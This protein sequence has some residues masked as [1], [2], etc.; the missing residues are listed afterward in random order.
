MATIRTVAEHAGVSTATVSRVMNTPQQVSEGTRARVET[1]M[2]ELNFSRN[3]VAASLVTRRSDCIGLIVGG[4]SGAFFAPLVNIVEETVSAAG[5]YLIVSCGKDTPGKCWRRCSFCA[6][7]N[8]T[9]SSCSPAS[10]P[11]PP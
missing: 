3:S 11:M 5:S 10:C 4:L 6:S 9:R 2:R 7:A 8:A 1:A